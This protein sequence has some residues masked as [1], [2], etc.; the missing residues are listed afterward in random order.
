MFLLCSLLYYN[1]TDY[2]TAQAL[3][4]QLLQDS[5]PSAITINGNSQHLDA[6]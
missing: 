5:H 2:A 1:F 4:P 6:I 3:Q